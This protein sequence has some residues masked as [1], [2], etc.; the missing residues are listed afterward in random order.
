MNHWRAALTRSHERLSQQAIELADMNLVLDRRVAERTSELERSREAALHNLEEA[1]EARG[2]AEAAEQALL[3]ARDAAEAANRAKSDFL[4]NMS[5]EIRTPMNGVIGMTEL[6]LDTELTTEQR[7]FLELVKSSAD[8]LLGLINDILDFS[9]IE[10][11]RL[12]LDA[13]EFDLSGA[14]DET[15]RS[16][17]PWAHQKGLELAY[18]VSAAV[19]AT[20]VGDPG[21]LRQIIVNLV[22]NALKFTEEGEVV[23]RVEHLRSEGNRE[24]VRFAVIDTGIGIPPATQAAIFEPFTQADS[25]TTRRFGGT[26][27]GL[28]ISKHLVE[29]MGGSIWVESQ[30]GRGSKFQFTVPFEARSEPAGKPPPRELGELHGAPVLVVDDN[31]TNRRILEEILTNWGMRPTLVD[32]GKAALKAMEIAQQ[33]GRPFLL[34]LLDYQMPDMDGFEVAEQIRHRSELMATTLMMLSSVGQRGDAQRCKELGVAAYLTK[35][36]RQ[37]LLLDAILTVLTKSATSQ[38]AALVTRHTLREAHQPLKVLLAEDNPVNRLLAVRIL[39]KYSH[40]VEVAGSGREAIEAFEAGPY[41]VVLMDVQM[42]EMDGLAAT[43]EIRRREEGTGRRIPIV[44]L[45]AHALPEDRERCIGAGMDGYLAKPFSA[46]DL[47]DTIAKV[48]PL[49]APGQRR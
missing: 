21:R 18:H 16:L 26:G 45:T 25:S 49:P 31:A 8:S 40:V 41:D 44:G 11:Q 30:P 22:S 48:L 12:D 32:G 4:A 23:L 43:A 15:V 47:F 20:V 35:P 42:P 39:E 33:A 29:L 6:A 1:Y 7:E 3:V 46:R 19:P 38:G 2:K 28:A 14:L 9:K 13:I 27:L 36:V 37:S 17:A 34:V 10:A 24:I 5:H